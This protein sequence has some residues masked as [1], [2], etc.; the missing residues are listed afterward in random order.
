MDISYQDKTN[1]PDINSIFVSSYL[2]YFID[3]DIDLECYVSK[4]DKKQR[5]KKEEE[6]AYM[7]DES[8]TLH[9]PTIKELEFLLIVEQD[10]VVKKKLYNLIKF[11]KKKTSN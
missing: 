9:N 10:Q 7:Y 5:L 2:R 4:N 3:W 6:I 8:G 11:W 1:I